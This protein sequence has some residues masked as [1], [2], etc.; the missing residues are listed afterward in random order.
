LLALTLALA[1]CSYGIGVRRASAPPLLAAW[2]ASLF[3][4]DELSPRTLQTL[5]RLDLANVYRR[6]P[7]DAYRR[8]PHLA[9]PDPQPDYLFALAEISYHLGRQA[10]KSEDCEAVAYYYFCAGYAYHFLFPAAGGRGPLSV[11]KNAEP[12]PEP[13]APPATAAHG[14]RTNDAF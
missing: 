6:H 14:H 2:K 3:E 10:E 4:A 11:V 5:R 12:G 8:L 1:G 7:Q 9:V 13:A